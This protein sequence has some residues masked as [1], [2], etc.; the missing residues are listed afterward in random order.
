MAYYNNL[1]IGRGLIMKWTISLVLAVFIAITGSTDTK[2]K[3]KTIIGNDVSAY[4]LRPEVVEDFEKDNGWKIVPTPYDPTFVNSRADQNVVDGKPGD[5]G[6]TPAKKVYGVRF[7]FRYPGYNFVTIFPPILKEKDGKDALDP[8][9]QEV[10]GP[11]VPLKGVVQKL[12]VWVMSQGKKYVLEGYIRD[13]KG[14][15]HKVLFRYRDEDG[16]MRAD[17]DFVG[18]RPMVADIPVDVPQEVSSF[19][20]HKGLKFVKFIVRSTPH[21]NTEPVYL[22]FDQLKT[23]T[24]RFDVHFDGA[25]INTEWGDHL[26]KIKG[27]VRTTPD[28]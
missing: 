6:D 11:A 19:P 21:T 22:F 26:Q 14:N 28:K 13:W 12:S 8:V 10:I 3:T 5:L 1:K 27:R 7:Q 16:R 9:T 20:K 2:A 24:N 25:E 15:T 23:L 4:Q 18:W 17:L